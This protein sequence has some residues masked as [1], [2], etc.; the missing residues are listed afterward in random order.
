MNGRKP[1]II[2]ASIGGAAA[3]L[4]GVLLL[5]GGSPPPS[6]QCRSQVAQI[7]AYQADARAI[8]AS[9]DVVSTSGM[10]QFSLDVNASGRL[11]RLTKREGCPLTGYPGGVTLK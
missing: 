7:G 8:N 9:N 4:A 10:T 1:K 5:T 2:L 11:L 3:I 6:A